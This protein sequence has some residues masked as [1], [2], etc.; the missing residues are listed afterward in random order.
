MRRL[1]VAILHTVS[2][3]ANVARHLFALSRIRRTPPNRIQPTINRQIIYGP[4]CQTIAQIIRRTNRQLIRH[5]V[6]PIEVALSRTATEG[7][8][9]L[10]IVDRGRRDRVE[11]TSRVLAR[12]KARHLTSRRARA[13]L[14]QASALRSFAHACEESIPQLTLPTAA[15]LQAFVNMP[16]VHRRVLAD[17]DRACARDLARIESAFAA[18]QTRHEMLAHDI[19]LAGRFQMKEPRQLAQDEA[20]LRVVILTQRVATHVLFNLSRALHAGLLFAQ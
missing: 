19:L 3:R 2:Q 20:I 10:Q 13:G 18:E 11:W 4:R 12:F 7:A 6:A 8:L 1:P 9:H 15:C 17:A 16:N 14:D 5:L